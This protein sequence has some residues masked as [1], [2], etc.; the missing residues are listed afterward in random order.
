MIAR[1]QSIEIRDG[2]QVA[3]SRKM[4]EG[5]PLCAV[6]YFVYDGIPHTGLSFEQFAIQ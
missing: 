2:G 1:I 5:L 6:R 3:D 4:K